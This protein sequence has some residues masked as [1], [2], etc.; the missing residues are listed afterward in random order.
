[1]CSREYGSEKGLKMDD[2]TETHRVVNVSLLKGPFTQVSGE[3]EGPA[4]ARALSLT[5]KRVET[6]IEHVREMKSVDQETR[7]A[8]TTVVAHL[9]YASEI[10]RRSGAPVNG[11]FESDEDWADLKEDLIKTIAAG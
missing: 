3:E 4:F 11:M 2:S 7:V 1:M 5:C 9:I 6:F 8:A 10:A